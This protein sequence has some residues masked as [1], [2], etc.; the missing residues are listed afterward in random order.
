MS[1]LKLKPEIKAEWVARL[2]SGRYAQGIGRLKTVRRV[3]GK[4]VTAEYCC[5]GVL[6]EIAA[7][8]GVGRWGTA[9]PLH[10]GDD[11]L[12]RLTFATTDGAEDAGTLPYAVGRWAFDMSTYTA[13]DSLCNPELRPYDDRHPSQDRTAAG[14]NDSRVPFTAIADDIE[15]N[16]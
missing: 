8:Q 10:Q 14:M 5:L 12:F 1:T 15:A 2:R 13:T 9:S 11:T 6:C 7:E 3:D 4:D 16:L